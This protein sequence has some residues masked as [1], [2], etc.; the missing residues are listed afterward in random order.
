MTRDSRRAR[1]YETERLIFALVDRPGGRAHT[2]QV[3]GAT[4]TL[5]AEARFGSVAAVQRYVDDVLA[6]PA[7][8]E[9]FAGARRPIRVRS[10][11]GAGAAHYEFASA[12]IAIPEVPDGRWALRE[13][14]VLHECAHHLADPWAAAHGPEFA[15][16]LIDLVGLVL[17][18]EFA[19][20]YRVLLGD[21]GLT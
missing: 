16:T 19:L 2:V 18:P 10:R 3:A 21:A 6:L 8:R 20:V 4:L 15:H 13:L 1:F 7:V 5:R 11:K 9:R 12:E 17:G 14:V